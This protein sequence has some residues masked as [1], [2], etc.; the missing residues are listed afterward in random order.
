MD[1]PAGLVAAALSGDRV[2][3]LRALRDR[4]AKEI[5][6]A[7]Q[8]RDVAALARQLTLIL[9]EIA[10]LAPPAQKKG[11]PLDEL[12]ERRAARGPAAKGKS[13]PAKS[14]V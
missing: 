2:A 1:A 14:A 4:I 5:E 3:T 11:T 6:T 10:T 12:R 13:R 9:G 8:S 7:E